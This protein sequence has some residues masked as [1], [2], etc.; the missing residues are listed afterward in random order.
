[1]LSK[2]YLNRFGGIER[3]FGQPGLE[4]L[5]QANVLIVGL[6][7]VGSWTAESLA[8][9]G[10]GSLSLMDY[11]EI[12]ITNTNRQIHTLSDTFGKLKIDVLSERLL[13]INPELKITKYSMRFDTDSV[14]NVLSDRFDYVVDAIDTLKFKCLLLSKCYQ[15]KIKIVCMGSSGGRVDPTMIK[16]SDLYQSG[17]DPLLQQTR[18]K[19]RRHFDM[20]DNRKK[21]RHIGI[22]SV[23][24]TE[25]Q[26]LP[27]NETCTQGPLD[28]RTGFGSISFV[29][30]AM[31]LHAAS[32]VVR[33]IAHSITD[34]PD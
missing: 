15:R 16:V 23:Y 7:G 31:G 20:P 22:P 33:S 10:V 3:L 14:E 11:D 21:K 30:G 32:V 13:A 18:K 4:R 29:T 24:S 1:M 12:C 25:P 2:P 17:D 26:I 28:C 19:L 5:H 8:R 34:L 27:F 6:G 9:S